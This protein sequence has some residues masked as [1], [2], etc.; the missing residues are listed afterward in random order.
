MKTWLQF[1]V[2]G[3]KTMSWALSHSSMFF[4]LIPSLKLVHSR[5]ILRKIVK[6]I[7]PFFKKNL[8]WSKSVFLQKKQ[9]FEGN[10]EE[11]VKYIQVH[12][13]FPEEE[14]DFL[15]RS[16][17]TFG[18]QKT[19]DVLYRHLKFI[20]NTLSL[21]N[22]DYLSSVYQNYNTKFKHLEVEGKG[23]KIAKIHGYFEAEL[24][25]IRKYLVS[26]RTARKFNKNSEAIFEYLD[27]R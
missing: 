11:L 4:G 27:H 9:E 18:L 20:L 14:L 24:Q 25:F 16:R 1:Y 26:S 3:S 2:H 19:E 13:R 17:P 8:G 12:K 21:G 23:Q 15:Q 7:T 22:Y 5:E 6:P 10:F